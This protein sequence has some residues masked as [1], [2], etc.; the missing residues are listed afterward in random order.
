MIRNVQMERLSASTNSIDKIKIL[1][2]QK[3]DSV[4]TIKINTFSKGEKKRD[5]VNYDITI[6][7]TNSLSADETANSLFSEIGRFI[8]KSQ[9]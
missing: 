1:N 4:I 7:F 3:Q 6:S 2:I 5:N 9:E 8:R